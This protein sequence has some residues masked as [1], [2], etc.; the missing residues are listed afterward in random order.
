M[1]I[2]L[3]TRNLVSLLLIV[4]ALFIINLPVMAE[5]IK[6]GLI[7]PLTGAVSTYGQSVRN[8]IVMGIDEINAEGG[9]DG[10]LINLIIRDDK[11]D[12]TE[13]A[14][15]ARYLIDR[16]QVCLI[17]GPIITPCV[18]AVAPIAQDAG[19][20]LMTPTGT[21]D[22]ITAIG[23]F[24]FRAAYKDSFQGRSMANF[25]RENLGI[26]TAAIIYDI[27]N[28]YSN[29]LMKSFKAAFEELGGKI[30][31][32]QSYATG[33]SDFSAQLTSIA[34]KNPDAIFIP[35]YHAA[36]GPILLQAS[37]FG[38]DAT[39][40]GVDGWDSPDLSALSGGNDEGGYFVNH[41]SPLDTR[42]ATIA[43]TTKYS[44]RFG[45]EPDALAALGYDAVLIIK[46]ALEKASSTQPEAL[47]NALGTVKNVVAATAT[48]DMDPEGTPHKPV[49]IIQIK[50]GLPIVVDRV[51]P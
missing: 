39:M 13:S 16:E 27:A 26:E 36:V 3:T 51:Y 8:S 42:E 23:D 40:L 7:T 31:S 34:M 38:I 24:I 20:P 46:A 21:G 5:E 10:K 41:Y 14:N 2:R 32:T 22:S 9:I 47:K 45:I 30:V 44:E 43:F 4:T 19:M 29:G 15:I 37:Q 1:N 35:D 49:V 33:D 25:A 11:G 6:V 17:I 48:I 12:A 18:M 50:D 28:D